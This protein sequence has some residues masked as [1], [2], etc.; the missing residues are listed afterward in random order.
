MSFTKYSIVVIAASLCLTLIFAG[1]C[2]VE[3]FPDTRDPNAFTLGSKNTKTNTVT[4]SDGV[5]MSH[6][7]TG[8][9]VSILNGE[10]ATSNDNVTY[11]A[12]TKEPGRIS[13]GQWLKVRHTSA[14]SIGV[15]TVTTIRVEDF[16]ATFTSFTTEAGV[17]GNSTTNKP[18]ADGTVHD[19]SGSIAASVTSTKKSSDATN[20][21]VT[22]TVNVSNTDLNQ[23]SVTVVVNGENS[24]SGTLII[25]NLSGT[26]SG[27]GNETF[28]IDVILTTS[29]YNKITKWV[30]A[31]VTKK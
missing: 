25:K 24:S 8:S 2:G 31:E 13:A 29:D 4:E 16:T 18:P 9:D 20:T 15:A 21:T 27:K 7:T 3:W 17:F 14:A 10:W 23:A 19:A 5:Q 28:S 22:L 26:V 12:W 11:S 1:G 30:I 6:N